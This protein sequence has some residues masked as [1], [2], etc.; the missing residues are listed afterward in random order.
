MS[1]VI[2]IE[3]V[4]SRLALPDDEGVNGAI[5]SAME[6]AHVQVSALL[7]TELGPGGHTDYFWI[8]SEVHSAVDGFYTLRLTNGFVKTITSVLSGLST[9]G[10]T[11]TVTGY[12]LNKERGWVK[13]PENYADTYLKVDYSFGLA[14]YS[15]CPPWLKEVVIG[16]T[17][18]TM[19][20]QQIS[21]G[22]PELSSVAAS[23]DK[24][25]G[26]ILDRR[27]RVGSMTIS[28]LV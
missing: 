13:V 19:S 4:R 8:D 24:V 11:D 12:L 10:L 17:I 5:Q 28:P 2:K 21:D 7:M 18:K 25:V 27:L 14:D 9:D 23:V 1:V 26:P 22:K 6:S 20:A 15:E 3:D 16:L